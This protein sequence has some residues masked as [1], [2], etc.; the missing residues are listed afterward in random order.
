MKFSEFFTTKDNIQLD[1]KT[2]VILRWIANVGQLFTIVIVYYFLN[3]KFL[4][5]YC[6]IIILLGALTNFVYKRI[7]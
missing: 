4:V 7:K 5:S 3:F 6:T 2:L 1:K